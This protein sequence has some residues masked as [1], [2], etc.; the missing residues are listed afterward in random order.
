LVGGSNLEII[1]RT[2]LGDWILI[3]AIGGNNPCWMKAEFMDIQGE[4][5]TLAPVD[6]HIILPWSPYY[7]PL[8]GVSAIRVGDTVTVSWAPLTLREGDEADPVPYV[9]EAWVCQS[10][11]LVFTPVGSFP[12]AVEILDESGCAEPSHGRVMAAE[13]HGYTWPVEVPWP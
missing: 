6:V 9:V 8:T 12:P 2:D 10:E 13:K 1:G 3:Q 4:T 11:Q 7:G 5:L